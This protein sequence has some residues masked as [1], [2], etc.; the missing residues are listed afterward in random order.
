MSKESSDTTASIMQKANHVGTA[1]FLLVILVGT[2]LWLTGNL[3]FGPVA[4]TV[5]G[6]SSHIPGDAH[7]Y[8]ASDNLCKEHGVLESLCVECKPE[9]RSLV[10]RDISSKANPNALEKAVC[11]HAV[12]TVECEK[13]RHEVGV[14]RVRPSVAEAL[15]ETGVVKDLDR[16]RALRLTGHVQLDKTRVVEVVPTGSGRVKRIEKLLGQKIRK[17]DVLA[18][19]HSADLGQAKAQ[20]LEVQA[21][22]ELATATFKREKGLHQKG[23]SS[24]ADYLGALNG[25]RAAE[26]NYSAVEKRLRL[27]GLTDE[28]IAAIKD[29][30]EDEHFAELV[31]RAPQAGTIIAQN[32]SV[33]TLVDTTTSV[34]TIADLSNVWVWCDLYEK[35]LAVLHEQSSTGEPITA[36]VR[37]KAFEDTAFDGVVDLIGSLV[38]EHT[39]TIR[40]RVQ[41]RN[42]EGKLKPGMFAEAEIVVPLKGQITAVPATAVLSDE[43]K[44]FVFQHWKDDLWLRRDVVVGRSQG[45]FVEILAGVPRGTRVVTGGAFMLKSDVLREKMGAGC[46]D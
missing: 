41:V 44:T 43:G 21:K 40:V 33:G 24:E 23:I 10:A 45:R 11:E 36:K 19:I 13:C 22:V 2:V 27:F 35:D 32:I 28:Q 31:L 3:H 5:V 37:V 38:D 7:Q 46:A 6:H 30:R 12:R 4:A 17:A 1:L 15:L 18:V 42:E 14:V 20:F 16:A 26:A 9:S 39:R 29:E 25:L 34:Y 8:E